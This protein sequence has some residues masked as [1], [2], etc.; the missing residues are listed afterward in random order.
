MKK[1][2]LWTLLAALAWLAGAACPV[3]GQGDFTLSITPNYTEVP[4]GNDLVLTLRA[5]EGVNL[6]A[7]DVTVVYNSD[8]LTLADWEYGDYF[9]NLASMAVSKQT[10]SLRVAATQ[11][12][13]P[14]VSGDG[15]V[16]A[17]TF[18]TKGQGYSFID[19][20]RAEFADS[21]GNKLA[22][23]VVNGQ[24]TVTLGPTYTPSGTSTPTAT[25]TPT[26]TRT[27][28]AT[29][30]ST[31]TS[32]PVQTQPLPSTGTL[33]PTSLTVTQTAALTGTAISLTTP[34]TSL[35]GTDTGFQTPSVTRSPWPV[36]DVTKTSTPVMLVVT[37]TNDAGGLV[38]TPDRDDN[39]RN[40]LN[41][42]LWGVLT[43]GV[44][45][46]MI[47]VV[48]ILRRRNQKEEDL[49]L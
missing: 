6:N 30:T 23:E 49:L 12:A 5:A 20:T 11:V 29:R 25:R 35:A 13:S 42:L 15:D 27:P 34:G 4:L 32:T 17:M 37:P 19:I 33:S 16:L 40:L 39:S 21:G 7:F 36:L 47:L 31:V 10:G 43:A 28:T 3:Y 2:Q 8:V 44:V 26:F 38:P 45:M 18:T 48:L 24:V 1:F 46:L 22:P 14:P 41:G 9:A